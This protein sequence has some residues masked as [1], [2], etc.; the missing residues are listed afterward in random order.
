MEA[1]LKYMKILQSQLYKMIT[2]GSKNILPSKSVQEFFYEIVT[3]VPKSLSLY[4]I[5]S[6]IDLTFYWTLSLAQNF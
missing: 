2:G 5:V 3:V 6:T 1:V 4:S